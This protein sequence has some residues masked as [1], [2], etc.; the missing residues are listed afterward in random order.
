MTVA[1]L[2]TALCL[3]VSD[4]EADAE[5]GAQLNQRVGSLPAIGLGGGVDSVFIYDTELIPLLRLSVTDPR[6][7]ASINYQP[8]M[9]LRFQDL[10]EGLDIL[11]ADTRIEE[12]VEDGVL[13]PRL[14]D[15]GRPFLVSHSFGAEFTY[16]FSPVVSWF[17]T[18]NGRTGENDFAIVSQNGLGINTPATGADSGAADGTGSGEIRDPVIES[19]SILVTTGLNTP[20]FDRHELTLSAS[21]NVTFPVDNRLV[22]GDTD[23]ITEES[24]E[25]DSLC[26]LDLA[27][28]AV[29]QAQFADTCQIQ[30]QGLA[31]FHLS[32]IDDLN[33]AATYTL[34]DFDPGAFNYIGQIDALWQ[35]QISP[36][37]TGRLGLGVAVSI[38]EVDDDPGEPLVTNVAAIPVVQA[39]INIPIINF[40]LLQLVMDASLLLDGFADP[41][42]QD[43]LLRAGA[44]LQFSLLAGREWT[45]Q[46][47]LQGTTLEPTSSS[48]PSRRGIDPAVGGLQALVSTINANATMTWSRDPRFQVLFGGNYS[49]RGPHL[50]EIGNERLSQV[51]LTAFVGIRWAYNTR[52][53]GLDETS[54]PNL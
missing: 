43:Y 32:A 44:A 1:I 35:R 27:N 34:V 20:L 21:V 17:L 53:P 6:W 31:R 38:S 50:S 12:S 24:Q 22:E 25:G 42:I 33:V 18:G 14:V 40:R 19:T 49:A 48:P 47:G 36:L 11:R 54:R 46:F 16:N 51:A 5:V 4:V 2:S 15:E 28:N 8:R 29:A 45:G 23:L 13:V 41:T 39:G 9:L 7:E 10:G 37:A 26:F 3:M 30:G 52:G